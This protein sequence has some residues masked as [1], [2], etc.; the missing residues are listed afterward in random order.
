MH[1]YM[2]RGSWGSS[3]YTFFAGAEALG[4]HPPCI[5]L[6]V[7]TPGMHSLQAQS[8]WGSSFYAFSVCAVPVLQHLLRITRVRTAPGAAAS[9]HSLRAWSPRG[10]IPYAFLRARSPWDSTFDVFFSLGQP[11]L[12]CLACAEPFGRSFHACLCA[13]S[14]WGIS[15]YT[16]TPCADPWGSSVCAS[17]ACPMG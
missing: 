2:C 1:F 14:P 7:Q 11:L 15:F 6:R 5:F 10:S 12:C 17:G 8:L 13:Q 16:F 3:F 9:I 4:Q